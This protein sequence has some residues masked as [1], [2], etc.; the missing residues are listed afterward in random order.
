MSDHIERMK[1]EHKELKQKID[2]LNAFIHSNEIFKGLDDLEQARMIKQA[3]FMESYLA[4]LDS[5][6]WCA[7]GE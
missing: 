4:V 5:R 2:A 1:R 6:I 7:Q 3:G